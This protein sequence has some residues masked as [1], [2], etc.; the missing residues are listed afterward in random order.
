MPTTK[1]GKCRTRL[2]HIWNGMKMRC[3][4]HRNIAYK[5]Y[6]AKGVSVCDEWRDDFIPFY[7]WAMA[8]GYQDS[9]TL[10]RID[11]DGNYCPENCRWATNKEQQN[12][13]AYNRLY[14]YQGDTLDVTQ[15][16]E[17]TGLPRN[18]I[19]KRLYR[20]WS[21]EKALTTNKLRKNEVT[22]YGCEL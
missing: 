11:T 21:I 4:N 17:R 12:N 6:G 22:N 14:T 7:E 20:G 3:S 5:Y 18:M 10:D 1:H 16:A 2:Y 8:N 15:W 9:L 19:Y 13:T